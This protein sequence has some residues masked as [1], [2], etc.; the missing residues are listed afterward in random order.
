MTNKIEI[1]INE[2]GVMRDLTPGERVA[3]AITQLNEACMNCK[4]DECPVCIKDKVDHYF[5]EDCWDISTA[6][7]FIDSKTIY[8]NVEYE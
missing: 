3:W 6:I 2:D 5:T 7:E 1:Q 4:C 8:I